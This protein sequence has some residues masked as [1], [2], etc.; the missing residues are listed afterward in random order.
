MAVEKALKRVKKTTQV[1]LNVVNKTN[2]SKSLTGIETDLRLKRD[3]SQT[4]YYVQYLVVFDS[5]IVKLFNSIY[6][7]IGEGNIQDY[8]R[9]QQQ[10]VVMQVNIDIRNP[11]SPF[12]VYIKIF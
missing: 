10:F 11:H 5:T 6:G 12:C 7:N 8:I 4:K 9:I 3:T 1:D 2:F